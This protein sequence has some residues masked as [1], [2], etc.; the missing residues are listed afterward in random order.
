MIVRSII[1]YSILSFWTILLGFICIP[2]LFLPAS[3]LRN[4]VRIWIKG[5]FLLLNFICQISHEIQGKENIPKKATLVASK[6]Q[7]AFETFA[8]IYYLP[9]SIFIHKK[10]LFWISN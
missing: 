3:Y 8:L 7:S 1:F 10:E 6:H 5:I 9:N 2:F 4:P